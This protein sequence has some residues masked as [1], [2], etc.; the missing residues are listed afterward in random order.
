[1][2]ERKFVFALQNMTVVGGNHLCKMIQLDDG[3]QIILAITASESKKPPDRLVDREKGDFINV[4]VR[5]R[6]TPI[7]NID[8]NNEC[9]YC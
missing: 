4:P 1:M 7:E 8:E 2:T 3:I 5:T 6:K 9:P